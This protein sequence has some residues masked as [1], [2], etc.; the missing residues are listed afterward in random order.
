MVAIISFIL[1]VHIMIERM[2]CEINI[3]QFVVRQDKQ[4]FNSARKL[5]LIRT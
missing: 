4:L 5:S 2:V 1:V 3:T